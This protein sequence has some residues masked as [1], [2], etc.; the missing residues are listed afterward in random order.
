MSNVI[1]I[2]AGMVGSTIAIDMAKKHTVTLTD[3]N[4]A[5]LSTIK[6]N[7]QNITIRTLNVTDRASLKEAIR[8]FDLVICAVPGY[9]GYNT[10]KA[11]IESG[12]KCS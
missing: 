6:A 10:L 5:V 12:K 9:L 3:F 4:P 11:I 7:H 8:S 1:V 2:G